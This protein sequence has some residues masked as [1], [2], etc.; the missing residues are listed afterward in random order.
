MAFL[1]PEELQTHLY[2]ENIEPTAPEDDATVAVAIDPP[3]EE[4]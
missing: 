4:A 1:T 2:K 3:I